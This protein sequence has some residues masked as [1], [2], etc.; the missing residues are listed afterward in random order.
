MGIILPELAEKLAPSAGLRDRLVHEYDSPDQA[1]ILK[2]V[3]TALK[4]YPPYIKAIS[5]SLSRQG[6][7]FHK[8]K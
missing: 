5:D 4:F 7:D 1:A 6:E 2:A 3:R 8:A